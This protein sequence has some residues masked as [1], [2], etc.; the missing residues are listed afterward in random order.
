MEPTP[1]S[2]LDSFDSMKI[3]RPMVMDVHIAGRRN[4]P[5]GIPKVVHSTCTMDAGKQCAVCPMLAAGGEAQSVVPPWSSIVLGMIDS[6]KNR[7]KE[8]LRENLGAMK[9]DRLLH[10][11]QSF[12]AVEELF[13][14]PSMD[15][16]N[17]DFTNRKI[18]G[19]GK[20]DTLPSQVVRI[21]GTTHPDPKDQHNQFLAWEIREV[22]SAIDE[23]RVTPDLVRK[24]GRFSP[25]GE[26]T[27]IVKLQETAYELEQSVTRIYG[28]LDLHMAIDLV[29][30]S[31]IAF[32]F[33]GNLVPRGWLDV[34]IVGDTRTGK[35]EAAARMAEHYRAGTM[36]NCEAATYAGIVAGLQQMGAGREWTITWGT[37]PMN[38]RRMVILDEA[39]GLA[40]EQIAQMSDIR[41]SGF[42]HIQKIQAEQAWARTRLLWLSNPRDASMDNFTYGVQSIAPLI[43]NR[44]DIA[45]FDFALALTTEDVT[46]ERIQRVRRRFRS[47]RYSSKSCHSL[48]MW[49]WS[50]S[51]ENVEW[52][53]GA[54]A[55][56]LD[57]ALRIGEHYV[58]QPP[59]IQAANVRFKIAR[60]AVALAAATFSTDSSG[61]K[62]I[63]RK[64]HVRD[65]VRFLHYLYSKE[66][67]GYYQLSSRHRDDVRQAA[68]SFY[69]AKEYLSDRPFLTRFLRAVEG[70]FRRDMLEQTLNVGREEANGI[71][72][73]LYSWRLVS[74]DTQ[75]IRILPM[76]NNLLREIKE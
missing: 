30:H 17:G 73:R 6:P 60:V 49:S 26:Q 5:Y 32:P 55:E 3:E 33:D 43:G 21:T 28:R 40:P 15:D 59:L 8:L 24:L 19:V 54:E 39:S 29:Y 34:L 51:P 47:P 44:E 69:E 53:D 57:L 62:L 58:D 7:Q 1:V 56:V 66:T 50:R 14:R 76:L 10:E 22:E 4:P 16:D 48:V 52:E 2:V 13:V 9:C 35:S 72:N 25:K 46:P 27:P 70:Q 45:R 63:I 37:V 41:S 71:I 20:H 36:V 67:F 61:R 12:Q 68:R 23:F 74:P 11:I 65:A 42:I 31:L 38:D 75:A 18:Y 64:A